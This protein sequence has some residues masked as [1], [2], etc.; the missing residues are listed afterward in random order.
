M[1]TLRHPIVAL[2]FALLL[3][4][5]CDQAPEPAAGSQTESRLSGYVGGE[6]CAGCHETEYKDWQNSHHDLAMQHA[7]AETILGDFN[8]S[9]FEHQGVTSSFYQRDGKFFIRTDNESGELA[10]F[11]V[12]YTFGVYPLQQY[13]LQLENGKIQALSIAWDS[14]SKTEGGQRWFHTYGDEPIDHN[15]V[16]HWTRQ[17]QNWDTMCADCHSTGLVKRYDIE[18]DTFGTSWEEIDVSCE[19]CHGPAAEHVAWAETSGRDSADNKLLR[20]FTERENISWILN[21]ETGNSARSEPRLSQLEIDT[22]ASCHSRR[23][24]FVAGPAMEDNFLDSHIPSLIDDGLYHPDRQIQDEVYVY[25]S[26]LQS[27]MYAKGVTCSDCHTPHSIELRAPGPQVCLQCHEADKFAVETHTLHTPGSAGAD[28]I[29]C[30][31]PPTSYMQVDP[32]HDHSFRIPRP[33]LSKE[34]GTPD[35]CVNCHKNKDSDWSAGVL[36]QRGITSGSHWSEL[37]S[38]AIRTTEMPPPDDLLELAGNTD[39]TPVIITASSLSNGLYVLHPDAYQLLEASINSDYPMVRFGAARAL[40][41]ADPA[42]QARLVPQLLND[43]VAAVRLEALPVA[44][45]I[46]ADVLPSSTQS[47]FR[48]VM[49]EYIDAQLANSER[50]ES[51]INLGNI[52]RLSNQIGKA[53]T[54]CLTALRINPDF[55]PA[56]V[57]LSDLYRIQQREDEGEKLL[58]QG[59]ARLPEAPVLKQ[60]LGLNLV[61]QQRLPE[62]IN[63]FYDAAESPQAEL[64]YVITYALALEAAG[65]SRKAVNYLETAGKRFNNAPELA[66]TIN[67]IAERANQPR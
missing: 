41:Y 31:M 54:A 21:N 55:I 5:G 10:E 32:R 61:R 37:F 22:C 52:Y 59:I 25:G 34:F 50:A 19:A 56:Y 18:S 36:E 11:E 49:Q 8:D 20:S 46:G 23:S 24:K 30:H 1:L 6:T 65:N 38:A 14:R 3:L 48:Q 9:S 47:L 12:I 62:A 29:E 4:S 58:R 44:A 7:S 26:F 33:W 2:L 28:C 27:K 16:L 60:V 63:V 45:A 43:P 66:Q 42:T 13:L 35:A 51:H 17:A 57:N 64:R 53:E 67:A 39:N 15:D 40:N